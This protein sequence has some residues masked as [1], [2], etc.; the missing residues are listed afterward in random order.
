[1]QTS[2]TIR[3]GRLYVILFFQK[4]DSVLIE[5]YAGYFVNILNIAAD[6]PHARNVR[7]FRQIL[8]DLFVS[9]AMQL[10]IS[11]LYRFQAAF[12]I[13]N[14]VMPLNHAE[15]VVENFKLRARRF[16]RARVKRFQTHIFSDKRRIGTLPQMQRFRKNLF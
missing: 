11:A 9:A 14:R 12:D 1:M 8:R 4:T 13:M 3:F 6:F 7:E 2:V 16:Q 15:F 5:K 10:F